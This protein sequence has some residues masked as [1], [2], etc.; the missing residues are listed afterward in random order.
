MAAGKASDFKIYD[1]Y[2]HAGR[3]EVVMQNAMAF[4]AASA[5]ALRII[6]QSRLGHYAYESIY[7]EI[8][9]FDSRRDITSV[10]SATLLP[11]T[12]DE[13]V[14]VKL[15]RKQGPIA[16]TID[17]FKK[18]GRT[19]EEASFVLGQQSA[20]AQLVTY[21][22]SACRGLVASIG[23]VGSDDLVYDA[24]NGTIQYAD[25]VQGL[26]IAGD[27]SGQI[28]AMV[29]HSKPFHDL[30]GDGL[31]NYKIENVAGVA[32]VTGIVGTMGRPVVVTDSSALIEVDGSDTYYYSLLLYP[33]AATVEES[34]TS[35]LASEV[36]T[37]NENIMLQW[38]YEYAF[39]LRL[40]G[41]KWDVANG[42][43]N[44]SDSAVATGTNWDKAATDNKSL[45]GVMV[46]SA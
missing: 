6:Q 34:E 27:Q 24:T 28:G 23:G 36:K 46:K 21:L 40:R 33:G 38:Q 45:A 12:Q 2:F 37:G 8:A 35:T 18:K 7:D 43:A 44:P 25:L 42:G 39:N 16:Q 19:V 11:M 29:M 3:T 15:N 5:N 26:A 10:S 4:N 20:K 9:S 30:F 41:F 22:N 17:S 32:I 13:E 14:S 1:D 31:A